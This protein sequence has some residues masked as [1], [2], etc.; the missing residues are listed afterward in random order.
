MRYS[1]GAEVDNDPRNRPDA[2]NIVDAM[3]PD[4]IVRSIHFLTIDHAELGAGYQWAFDNPEFKHLYDDFGAEK[5][6]ELYMA[7]LLEAI[8]KLPAHIV[9]HFYVPAKFGHWPDDETLQR[10]EDQLLDAC[11]ERGLAVEVNARVFYRTYVEDE[12]FAQAQRQKLFRRAL[13]P[14][15][16]RPRPGACKSPSV[17]TRIA[18]AI[19]ATASMPCCRCSMRPKS[20]RSPSR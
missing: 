1:I 2:Q 20:T 17:R 19:R 12:E 8:E 14:C 15:C 7:G 10:Y 18:R 6:W 13:A 4:A 5:V 9:G 11:A 16:E 3:R